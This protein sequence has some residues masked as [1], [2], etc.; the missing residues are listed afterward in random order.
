MLVIFGLMPDFIMHVLSE[1]KMLKS[2]ANVNRLQ[3]GTQNEMLHEAAES[4]AELF[5]SH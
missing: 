3:N 5:S 2:V 1:A 4:T